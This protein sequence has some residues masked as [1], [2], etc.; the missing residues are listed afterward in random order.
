MPCAAIRNW[1]LI[2]QEVSIPPLFLSLSIIIILNPDSP[3][4]FLVPWHLREVNVRHMTCMIVMRFAWIT[5]VCFTTIVWRKY[6]TKVYR[7]LQWCTKKTLITIGVICCTCNHIKTII[8]STTISYDTI[9]KTRTIIYQ[10]T[11][12]GT[13]GNRNMSLAPLCMS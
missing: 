2:T 10:A 12:M 11:P 8:L 13:W 4:Q 3:T 6:D 7:T 5:F 1:R 9:N